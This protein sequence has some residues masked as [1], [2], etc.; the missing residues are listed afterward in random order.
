MQTTHE[1]FDSIEGYA[2]KGKALI[3]LC[4]EA[5]LLIFHVNS[6]NDPGHPD[7]LRK[8]IGIL[9]KDIETQAK[10][11]GYGEDDIKAVRYAL[12]ALIDETLLNSRWAFKNQWSEQPLQLEFFGEHLAGEGFFEL[13]D[14][15][16]KKGRRKAD[17]LEVFCMCLILGLRGKYRLR[18]PEEVTELTRTLVEETNAYRSGSSG[19]SPHWKIPEEAPERP[20]HAVPK[21]VLITAGSSVLVVILVFAA[22][23]L[24]LNSS[25][26]DL[27]QRLSF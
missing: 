7:D 2:G 23:K 15:I 14:R 22:L 16:R 6:G 27:I 10:R 26:A 24:W 19:L 9:F 13:L 20:A 5:F 11:C 4:S 18:N 3:D 12:C 17:L 25:V 21:W 8:N 1:D